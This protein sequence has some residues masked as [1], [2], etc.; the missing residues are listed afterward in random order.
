MIQN[1]LNLVGKNSLIGNLIVSARQLNLEFNVTNSDDGKQYI[2]SLTEIFEFGMSLR[3]EVG[4]CY[5]NEKEARNYTFD[6]QGK[7]ISILM[8]ISQT[9]QPLCLFNHIDERQWTYVFVLMN[10]ADIIPLFQQAKPNDYFLSNTQGQLMLA[11][12][13]HDFSYIT[14]SS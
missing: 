5:L 14:Q 12:K 6:N 7:F 1:I 2:A 11:A 10:S 8:E 13:W 3:P 9:M 4:F